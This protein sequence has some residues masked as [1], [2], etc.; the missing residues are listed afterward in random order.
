MDINDEK[1]YIFEQM[2]LIVEERRKLTEIYYEWKTRLQQLNNEYEKKNETNHNKIEQPL[3]DVSRESTYQ[4]YMLNKKNTKQNISY[5]EVSL[6]IASILKEA[7]KPLSNKEIFKR[8]I[9][10][11]GEI[12]SKKNL[13]CNILPR[14]NKDSRIA[15]ERAY[16]GYWQY[17]LH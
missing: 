4:Q 16:H 11:K 9:A 6:T 10:Q 13:T 3:M 5:Q 15:V 7:G 12:V 1:K 17:R 8:L 14:I 2:K